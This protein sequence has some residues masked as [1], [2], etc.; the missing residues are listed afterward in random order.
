MWKLIGLALCFILAAVSIASAQET[1]F[2]QLS[3]FNPV[4][5]VPEDQSIKGISLDLFYTV[6]ADVTGFSLSFLGVNRVTGNEKGV[7][8]GLGN[9]DEGD[10]YG[11]SAGLLNYT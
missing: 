6:N 9:W 8:W 1:K 7:Q 2:L 10:T 11:W 3:L 5:M 4:Q